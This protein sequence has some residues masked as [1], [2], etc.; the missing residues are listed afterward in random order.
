[1]QT[2]KKIVPIFFAIDENYIPF[3]SV[4]LISLKE[5]ISETNEYR[6]YILQKGIDFHKFDY[7]LGLNSDNLKIHIVDVSEKLN[8]I[9][10]ELVL[11]DYYTL[12]TYYR[13]FIAE[14]FPEYD[15]VIYLD[16][17]TIVLKDIADFFDIDLTNYL[18]GGVPDEAV[19]NIEPFSRYVKKALG[20][21]ANEYFNAG[22]MVMNLKEFR[23]FNFYKEFGELLNKYKFKVA[24]D[25]DYLNVLCYKKAKLLPYNWNVMPLRGINLKPCEKPYIIHF[26]LTAKPWHYSDLQYEEYFWKYAKKSAYYEDILKQKESFTEEMAKKDCAG[27]SNL[28]SMCID[29]S[30]NKDNYFNLYVKEA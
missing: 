21:E 23:K 15:K 11:R 2:N 26:N 3:L 17:D 27:E 18:V 14:M 20:I 1:M 29:E 4:S 25:Q 24:Q 19:G 5:H 28:L 8:E 9:S 10:N 7:I 13:I 30:E 6:V 12:T 16:S 22:I